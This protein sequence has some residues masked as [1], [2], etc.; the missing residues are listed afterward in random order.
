MRESIELSSIVLKIPA[1]AEM[2]RFL[3]FKDSGTA[4]HRLRG[5]DGIIGFEVKVGAII[6]TP[7]NSV[8]L[9]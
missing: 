8:L 9:W 1:C 7:G 3:N 2:T 6:F 5:N 4:D